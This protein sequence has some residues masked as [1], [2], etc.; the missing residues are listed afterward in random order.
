M[1]HEEA[2]TGLAVLGG[3]E[4]AFAEQADVRKKVLWVSG[5]SVHWLGRVTDMDGRCCGR[6][7]AMTRGQLPLLPTAS[8]NLDSGGLVG[9]GA[10]NIGARVVTMRHS[11][12]QPRDGRNIAKDDDE[13]P[14]PL[15]T[16]TDENE[17]RPS[18]QTAA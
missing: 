13:Q 18:A 16:T 8:S 10:L 9:V 11:A 7:V 4:G 3:R 6:M 5:R 1:N 17:N 14:H 2:S 12:S 15:L